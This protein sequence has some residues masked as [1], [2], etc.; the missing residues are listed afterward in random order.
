MTGT[1]E[2]VQ[3]RATGTGRSV[4]TRTST[5]REDR[6]VRGSQNHSYLPAGA[7]PSPLPSIFNFDVC[8]FRFKKSEKWEVKT[9]TLPHTLACKFLA[10]VRSMDTLSI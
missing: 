3:V 4:S 6:G 10:F 8:G 1:W 7:G 5:Y 2:A 9:A